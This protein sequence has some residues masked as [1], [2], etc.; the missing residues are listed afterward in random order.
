MRIGLVIPTTPKYSETFFNSKIKGLLENGFEVIIFTQTIASDFN[1]CKTVKSPRVSGS[2]FLVA[3]NMIKVGFKLLFHLNNVIK[4]YKLLKSSGFALTTIFKRM[5]LNSHILSHSVDWLHFGFATQ[6]IGSEYVA[7]A[8]GAKMAVSFRGFDINVY[9]LKYEN[10]YLDV[11]K[12]VDKVHSISQY[13]VEQAYGL[14]LKKVIPFSIITPAVDDQIFKTI[15]SKQ[16]SVGQNQLTIC[17]VA[18][19]NWIKDLTTALE[20]IQLLKKTYPN[21]QYHIIGDGDIKERERYL[22]LVNQLGLEDN[23]VFHRKLSH[24]DTL[25]LVG[26]SDIYLQTSLN[27]GFCN[28]VLEAQALGRLCVASDVG[29]LKENIID[30]KTGWLVRSQQPNVFAN[31]IIEVVQLPEA[32]K[33]A[34]SNN[35]VS[36]VQKNF[37]LSYQNFKFLQFYNCKE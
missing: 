14:G 18:R 4:Y 20:T 32:K 31:K 24:N 7:K 23:V 37:T 29:G 35:A 17:S 6:A 1:L 33:I 3:L 21:L 22:F 26:K 19:L 16:N 2:R 28:A 36:R 11:W 27:E 8:I 9:P 13:L 30:G 34:V 12:N 10:C 5:Y 25:E 15:T